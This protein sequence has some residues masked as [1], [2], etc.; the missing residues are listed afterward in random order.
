[1]E[2]LPCWSALRACWAH[3]AS[4][5]ASRCC[6]SPSSICR[7]A[8]CSCAT[9]NSLQ[10]SEFR[11]KLEAGGILCT[12]S[13]QVTVANIRRIATVSN[14]QVAVETPDEIPA[15]RV[16]TAAAG[17]QLLRQALLLAPA[18]LVARLVCL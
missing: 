2:L 10:G 7:A 6:T 16:D 15:Q 13:A 9:C 5:W 11:Y 12:A 8:A 18:Q 3:S 17:L 14:R 4:R 1:M